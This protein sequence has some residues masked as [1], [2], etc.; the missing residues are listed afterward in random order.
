MLGRE[1]PLGLLGSLV[2]VPAKNIEQKYEMRRERQ[3]GQRNE[4]A[5]N[6]YKR[7]PGDTI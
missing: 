4:P 6:G 2:A 1:P 5:S 7:R 3:H